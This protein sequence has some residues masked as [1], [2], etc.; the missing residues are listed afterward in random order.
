MLQGD[1]GL[2]C[3]GPGKMGTWHGRCGPILPQVGKQKIQCSAA[4]M[5][6]YIKLDNPIGG[7]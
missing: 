4:F 7:Q 3:E 2:L 5:V 6:L 1:E